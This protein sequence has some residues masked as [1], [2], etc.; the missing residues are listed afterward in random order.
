LGQI[1]RA[2]DETRKYN[3]DAPKLKDADVWTC[4]IP[5]I[6][7]DPV[8]CSRCKSS[9]EPREI[10]NDILR[11]DAL[12]IGKESFEPI[13]RKFYRSL[14][15]SESPLYEAVSSENIIAP[16]FSHEAIDTFVDLL[17][18]DFVG[19]PAHL[20][21][22]FS[23]ALD[24]LLPRIS[25]VSDGSLDE[26]LGARLD[27]MV[28]L[29]LASLCGPRDY[30]PDLGMLVPSKSERTSLPKKE[31]DEKDDKKKEKKPAL[32]KDLDVEQSAY[33][34][35]VTFDRD[36]PNERDWIIC[37]INSDDAEDY[38]TQIITYPLEGK[39]E[40]LI[41]RGFKRFE[42]DGSHMMIPVDNELVSGL[43]HLRMHLV[44]DTWVLEDL[45]STNGTL[46]VR[47][48]GD[49]FFLYKNA[50]IPEQSLALEN[51]DVIRLAPNWQTK[52]ADPKC[53][54]FV[55]H[56]TTIDWR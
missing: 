16:F 9:K 24:Q 26:A 50:D 30:R 5:Q 25:H 4:F 32:P 6:D 34:T 20:Y 36:P 19:E 15:A 44:N 42:D 12:A 8:R 46:V 23:T 3:E 13:I 29:L 1:K 14:G 51:G 11:D 49:Q 55:F 47:N 22:E 52:H 7:N 48:N 56:T 2:C 21:N 33:L 40:V 37:Q 41:A 27:S 31:D 28:F 18:R 43:R 10:V 39:T 54:A 45:D 17:H 53:P 38:G 35:R